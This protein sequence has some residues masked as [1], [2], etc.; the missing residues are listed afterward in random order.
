MNSISRIRLQS[1]MQRAQK[2]FVDKRPKS[3][4]LF[5]RARN[6]LLG[7]VPMN[8]MAKWAG[9]FPPFVREAQGA[10]FYDVDGHRY[11]DLCLGD[12]GAMTGHS[13]SATVKAV[14]EQ[15]RRGITLMIQN[16]VEVFVGEE[17]QKRFGRPY[18]Q[19]ALTARDANRFSMSLTG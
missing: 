15:V 17:L 5:E 9:A 6:S 13:P 3:K 12:T 14:E 18:C 4:A 16:E 7:G 10:H 11:V 1:L 19:F 2:S 8:W